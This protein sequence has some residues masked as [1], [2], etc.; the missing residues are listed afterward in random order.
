[1]TTSRSIAF[2][3]YDGAPALTPDDRLAAA[4][5]A[6]RGIGVEPAVWSDPAVDWQRY[7]AVVLRSTWDYHRRVQE[8][9]DWLD[10]LEGNRVP[11][12]NP[13][14]LAR[15]NLDKRYL[16]DLA[17]R[18]VPT[19]PTLWLE[20]GSMPDL[21]AVLDAHG[22]PE[23]VL[24]PV[25]AAT[26]YRTCR[27]ARHAPAA[28][29]TQLRDAVEEVL[30][31]GP[32]MLQPLLPQIRAEGEWSLIFFAGEFSHAVLKKPTEGDFRVQEE[33]GGT[34]AAATPPPAL[35]VA[36]RSILDRIAGPWL[37]ARVD[38]VRSEK[39]GFLLMELEM[40]EPLLFLSLEASAPARFA[41]AILR[42]AVEPMAR[43]IRR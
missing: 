6:G 14:P 26:A 34:S 42:L 10:L 43:S 27:I 5:L 37:Y 22:W 18:G 13:V 36:A 17:G 2:A 25:V 38:G 15:W 31:D 12:W 23:A 9:R 30:A 21:P 40:L 32:A 28:Q 3:T 20:P 41:D 33:F 7:D 8:F 1:M 19:V 4:A 29:Q 11:L 35:P 39:G 24:K 16:R